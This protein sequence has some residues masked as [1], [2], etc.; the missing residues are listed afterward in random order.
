MAHAGVIVGSAVDG[1]LVE[2][3]ATTGK[4]FPDFASAWTGLVGGS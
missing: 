2:D 4:T 3:I 1:V